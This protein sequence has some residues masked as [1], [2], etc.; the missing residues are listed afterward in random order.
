M[1]QITVVVMFVGFTSTTIVRA[2]NINE[3]QE[4]RSTISRDIERNKAQAEAKRKEGLQI[5]SEIKQIN[6]D[7]STTENRIYQT[8]DAIT[9]VEKEI[10]VIT[11][12]IATKENEL[13]KEYSNQKE[14]VMT[15]YETTAQDPVYL[16]FSKSISEAVDKAAYIEALEIRIE[17]TID[18]VTEMRNELVEDKN[19]LIS[20]QNELED[21]KKQHEAYKKGLEYQK[22]NKNRLL[23]EVKIAEQDYKD[24][25]AE[26]KKAYQDVNSELYRLMQA[27]KNKASK[28]S[29][30]VGNIIFGW[31]FNGTIT[32]NFGVP[33]PVQ[34]FH[35]G[36][37]IDGVIGDP[38]SAAATGEVT[39]VGGSKTYGYGLYVIIDHGSGVSTLYGHLS[40]FSVSVGDVVAIGDKIG[41]MGNTGYAFAFSGGDGSHLHFEVR[42]DNVPVNPSVYLP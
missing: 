6:G 22:S 15:I 29:K 24:K 2:Q 17:S 4:K 19:N 20:K 27:A 40:G 33:T 38:I 7:I 18:S 8:E 16:L 11:S 10:E 39:F 30:K 1:L 25:L 32:A 12:N 35:T 34:S 31:P 23:V 21:L 41:Y 13:A 9:G 5:S 14:A 28:G 3:L 36:I 37:D 26:A 42:E